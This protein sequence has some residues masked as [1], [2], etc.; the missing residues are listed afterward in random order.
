MAPSPLDVRGVD[1]GGRVLVAVLHEEERL[2]LDGGGAR[3]VEARG[4]VARR[5]H[6]HDRRV[7]QVVLTPLGVEASEHVRATMSSAPEEF[8]KLPASDQRVL[9]DILRRALGSA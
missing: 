3:R 7:K 2:A 5:P 8:R 6:A 9:R 1:V 4:L